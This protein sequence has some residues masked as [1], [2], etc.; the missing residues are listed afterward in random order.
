MRRN[1]R[2]AFV[3]PLGLSLTAVVSAYGTFGAGV[4][5]ASPAAKEA[6]GAYAPGGALQ[7]SMGS[8]QQSL[9]PQL[10]YSSESEE[11]D[12]LVYTPLVT[13]SH[14]SGLAGDVLIPGLATALP[15]VSDGGL[16]RRTWPTPSGSLASSKYS[17][18][19]AVKASDFPYT[20][21]RDLK[22]GWSGDSWYTTTIAG[23]A[24][25]QAGKAKTI[26]GI[27]ADDATGQITIHLVSPYGA[28]DNI[29]AFPSA[30]LVPSRR[31]T[32]P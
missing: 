21:E 26:S 31:R 17:N 7:V 25:Y 2:L 8:L 22:V 14:K 1:H 13:Y 6:N 9:D 10:G 18:G 12:W 24:A 16:T 3:G 23:A 29:L 5:G 11:A 32:P 30:G 28:F 4:S 27:T 15:T 20:I 19:V